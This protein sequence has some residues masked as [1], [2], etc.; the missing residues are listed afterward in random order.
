MSLFRKL[1]FL[2]LLLIAGL[3]AGQLILTLC[4]WLGGADFSLAMVSQSAL[5][6]SMTSVLPFKL[7][8]GINNLMMFAASAILFALLV[9]KKEWLGYFKL[10]KSI[11]ISMLLWSVF[12]M[13]ASYPL[14]YYTTTVLTEIDL[15]EWAGSMDDSSIELLSSMLAMNTPL[16]FIISL[17]IIAIIPAIAEELFFRGALQKLLTERMNPHVGI[18]IASFVF[19][20]I[21]FQIVGLPPKLILGLVLGY[22]FYYTKNLWYPIILHFLN[23]GT[24]VAALYFSGADINSTELEATPS[25]PWYAAIGSIIITIALINHIAQ[26]NKTANGFSA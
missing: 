4:M 9:E 23:N 11:D 8:I 7:G 19:A 24:Q 14:L 12:A 15:P 13:L 5:I 10:N 16:D 20:A 2:F 25:M 22:I 18:F 21:H 1:L 17:I 3:I 6:E 26:Q